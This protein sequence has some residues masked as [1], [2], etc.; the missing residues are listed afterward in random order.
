V[1]GDVHVAV[2]DYE[3]GGKNTKICGVWFHTAFVDRPFLVF[4]KLSLDG[5]AKKKGLDPHFKLEIYLREAEGA[6]FDHSD[7]D[8]SLSESDDETTD[9]D[10]PR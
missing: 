3:W 7:A 10:E 5:A 2:Y 8:E 1:R 4:D 6:E 9:E